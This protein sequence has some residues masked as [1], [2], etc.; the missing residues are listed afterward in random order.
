MVIKGAVIVVCTHKPNL[1][2]LGIVFDKIRLQAGGHRV[3]VVENARLDMDVEEFVKKYKFKYVHEEQLGI[4]YARHNALKQVKS[5]ELLIFVDDDNFISENYVETALKLAKIHPNWGAFGGQQ[6]ALQSLKV[7]YFKSKSLPFLAIRSLGNRILQEKATFTWNPLEPVGAGMCLRPEVVKAALQRIRK[8]GLNY[9]KMGRSGTR[10][11]SG[12]DSYLARMAAGLNLEYG[13]SPELQLTHAI[14]SNRLN[15]KYLCKIYFVYG[16]TDIFLN[17]I[18][19]LDE[20]IKITSVSTMFHIFGSLIRNFRNP[21]WI[22]FH[23]GRYFASNKIFLR[24]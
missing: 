5:N 2:K 9:F 15:S 4:S 1:E 10:L 14:E 21:Y 3:V 20:S 6:T 13:Y 23:L 22:F 11:I 17:Q 16:I 12:E 19:E 7:S 18:F 8:D 24:I